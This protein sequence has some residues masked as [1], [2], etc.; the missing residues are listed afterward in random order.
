MIKQITAA[1]LLAVAS[2]AASAAEP[3][4]YVG[5]DVGSSKHED[6]DG[7]ETS[8]GIFGGYK[9]DENFAIEAGYRNLGK[10]DILGYDLKTNQLALSVIG[11]VPVADQ[12]AV[13][14]RLGYNRVEAKIAGEKDH[15]NKALYGVGVSYQ[16]TKEI[17]G[18]VEWQR[19]MS[20]SSNISAG[21]AYHF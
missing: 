5:G 4:F 16:F 9:F 10:W 20:G 15:E 3:Q 21:V 8:V 1:T 11:S 6:L 14:G 19:P 18:R 13:Y 17:S 12:V 7:R 2:F